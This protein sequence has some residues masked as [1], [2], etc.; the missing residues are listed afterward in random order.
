MHYKGIYI[1]IVFCLSLKLSQLSKPCYSKRDAFFN[2]STKR[3]FYLD[4]KDA[5]EA[6]SVD[7]I[8]N[9]IHVY[10]CHDYIQLIALSHLLPD[11]LAENNKVYLSWINFLWKFNFAD[12]RF[13]V[14]RAD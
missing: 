6:F 3:F 14:F 13:S 9:G 7:N 5:V 8:L 2:I 11:Y 10:R 4:N 1:Y 12:V